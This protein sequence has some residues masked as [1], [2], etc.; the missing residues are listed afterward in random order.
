[1]SGW[2]CLEVKRKRIIIKLNPFDKV[3]MFGIESSGADKEED[4]DDDSGVKYKND[5]QQNRGGED[6]CLGQHCPISEVKNCPQLHLIERDGSDDATLL[7][8]M[9]Q[10]TL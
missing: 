4:D 6:D 10:E 7:V 3:I 8:I 5:T 9:W 2:N 1:M